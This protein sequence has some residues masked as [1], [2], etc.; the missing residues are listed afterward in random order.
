MK[1][2]GGGPPSRGLRGGIP[3]L[4]VAAASQRGARHCPQRRSG[5]APPP[6]RPGCCSDPAEKSPGV[7]EP[8][9]RVA[10]VAVTNGGEQGCK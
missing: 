7:S 6:V 1:E 3:G 9:H 4:P 8:R 2:E 5:E 10:H